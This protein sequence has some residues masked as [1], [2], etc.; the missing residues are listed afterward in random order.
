MAAAG[1]HEVAAARET[2]ALTLTNVLAPLVQEM[3]NQFIAVSNGQAALAG[4]LQAVL[5]GM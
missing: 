3:D 5:A 4:K 1:E 2:A